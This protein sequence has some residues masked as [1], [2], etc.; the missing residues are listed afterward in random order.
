MGN[1]PTHKTAEAAATQRKRC[2]GGETR[3]SPKMVQKEGS[4]SKYISPKIPFTVA[5]HIQYQKPQL[6]TQLQLTEVEEMGLQQQS[7]CE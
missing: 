3:S 6:P 7:Q 4:S 5:V 1:I 2:S